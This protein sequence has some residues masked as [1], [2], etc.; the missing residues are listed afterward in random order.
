M[1]R[2][3]KSTA[4][5]PCRP[6]SMGRLGFSPAGSFTFSRT[7]GNQ[8]KSLPSTCIRRSHAA[9]SYSAAIC[10]S[11]AS[12]K[13]QRFD[14]RLHPRCSSRSAASSRGKSH[15]DAAR[16]SLGLGRDNHYR[17]D[18]PVHFQPSPAGRVHRHCR[19]SRLRANRAG[20]D[21]EIRHGP[22]AALPTQA[23]RGER[24]GN[25]LGRSASSAH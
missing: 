4:F 7:P 13:C 22:S 25:G 3:G 1:D 24:V 18:G 2:F 9:F 8:F 5:Q 11:C 12:S 21:R 16:E 23:R 10:I 15:G 17:C 20:R 14:F 19:Q 6:R